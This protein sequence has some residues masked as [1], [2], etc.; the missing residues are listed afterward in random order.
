MARY[1]VMKFYKSA[2]A[3][4][5]TLLP[6]Q[7]NEKG[8]VEREG[9]ILV[10]VAK[11]DGNRDN[12]TWDWDK[13]ISFAISFAD[14][15]NLLDDDSTKHRIFHKHKDS[16]KT[17]Q[18]VPATDPRWAG[19]YMLQLSAGS[20]DSRSSIGVPISGGEYGAI[21]RCLVAAM[22]KLIGWEE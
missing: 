14:I 7:R 4:Q 5:F 13:K 2:G 1:G 20:K 8:Y 16:P 17:L 21:M 6:V 18:F 19:T 15:C 22:P 9:A 10:E 12:P 11:G 3:A